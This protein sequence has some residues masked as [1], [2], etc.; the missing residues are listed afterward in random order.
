MLVTTSGSEYGQGK[1]D[2]QHK[3]RGLGDCW[4]FRT[5]GWDGKQFQVISESSTG[6]CRLIAPGGAWRLPTVVTR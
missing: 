4:S 6:M 2:E 3:G 1:I 5:L